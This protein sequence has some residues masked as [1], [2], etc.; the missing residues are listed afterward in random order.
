VPDD[1]RWVDAS[2]EEVGPGTETTR[3]VVVSDAGG[4]AL[5]LEVPVGEEPGELVATL[6]PAAMLA[7]DNARLAAVSRARLAEVRASQRRIVDASDAER[8][9]IE[10]DLHDGAQQRLVGAS[11]Q[12]SLARTHLV[13]GSE[14]LARAEVAV[15]EAV[16]RLRHLGHGIFPATLATEGL[17]AALEDVTRASDVPTTLDVRELRP[18]LERDT[19]LAAYAVCATVLA[20]ANQSPGAVSA[21]VKAAT[22]E[23]T[24]ELRVALMGSAGLGQH[25]LVDLADRVGAVGGHLDVEPI[26]GGVAIIA[27]M[28][29]G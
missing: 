3:A 25:D 16:A 29:C 6:T 24:M 20:H 22:R 27:V 12:L 15:G 18:G 19:A 28:P 13:A 14:N 26:D 21:E 5:R 17:G 2:G 11:F 1:G 23:G 10:R 8:Q 7:L 9:R 4:P